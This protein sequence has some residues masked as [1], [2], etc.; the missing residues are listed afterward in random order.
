MSDDTRNKL[1]IG[2]MAL[3]VIAII[4]N[5]LGIIKVPFSVAY[6]NLVKCSVYNNT[7]CGTQQNGV[8]TGISQVQT[9]SNFLG[10]SVWLVNFALNRAGQFLVGTWT[11]G[12]IA[13]AYNS[14]SSNNQPINIQANL[15]REYLNLPYVYQGI[16]VYSWSY[17][18][19]SFVY[20]ASINTVFCTQ[21]PQTTTSATYSFA[22]ANINSLDMQ[23]ALNGYASACNANGGTPFGLQQAQLT[24][25]GIGLAT[26][27]TVTC[28]APRTTDAYSFW[29]SG[30]PNLGVNVSIAYTQGS[31]TQTMTMTAGNPEN[32]IGST[33]YAQIYGYLPGSGSTYVGAV[34]PSVLCLRNVFLCRIIQHTTGQGINQL[35]QYSYNP[36]NPTNFPA[37]WLQPFTFTVAGLPFSSFSNPTYLQTQ[38][39]NQQNNVQILAGQALPAGDPYSGMTYNL[40]TSS[41]TLSLTNNPVYYP[42]IQFLANVS[43]LGL[44][45]YQI[46]PSIQS[47]SPNPVTASSGTPAAATF[48]VINT[49][50]IPGSASIY[51]TCG[52][53]SFSSPNFNV[54]ASGVPATVGV[55]INPPTTNTTIIVPCTAYVKSVQGSYTSPAFNFNMQVTGVPGASTT[56]TVP[57]T[58]QFCGGS[59]SS[60]PS[61][62]YNIGLGCQPG[63]YY[64]LFI[65][66]IAVIGYVLTRKG[67]L[68]LKIP[69]D[70][71]A[72]FIYLGIAILLSLIYTNYLW[73][74]IVGGIILG[75]LYIIATKTSI[76]GWL[77]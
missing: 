26:S 35:S 53:I 46:Q 72:I 70:R 75:I 41:G 10:K 8:V 55:T 22:C 15:S 12:Q 66:L 64:L 51:G 68:D 16:D 61:G 58:G 74:V 11:T 27:Y 4:L 57:C 63:Y 40:S 71:T 19:K 6:T 23:N 48:T 28:L 17:Q 73:I 47:V 34:S 25:A 69:K 43:T 45:A 29:N 32:N 65:I 56:T 1:I 9:A 67:G 24:L 3:G 44:A 42:Q 39:T 62:Y 18:N 52:A 60:C 54:P 21:I 31:S 30:S 7:F 50:S 37:T 77:K 76:L 14:T 59:G 13:S 33:L 49:A 2:I 36:A 38:L 20:S 5:S